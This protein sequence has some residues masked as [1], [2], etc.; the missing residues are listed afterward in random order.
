MLHRGVSDVKVWRWGDFEGMHPSTNA[1]YMY[2]NIDNVLY[3]ET[4]NIRMT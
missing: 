1:R 4:R 3:P 2:N